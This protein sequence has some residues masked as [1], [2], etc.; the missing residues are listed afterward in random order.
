MATVLKQKIFNTPWLYP[1]FSALIA[2]LLYANTIAHGY[3]LD[4][5]AVIADNQY[6]KQGIAG[7]G[8]L[9][10]S[11]MWHFENVK[12]GYYRPLSL[13]TFAIEQQ[14]FGSS[15]TISHLVNILLYS[16]TAWVT[17]LLLF[18][19][20]NRLHPFFALLGTL[21]F[22]AHP[23]H[24]EV[25]AN[26]K[27]R[28]EILSFLNLVIASWCLLQTSES[29]RNKYIL[30]GLSALFFYLAL[31]SKESAVVGVVLIPFLLWFT[32]EVS[33]K[34]LAYVV[35]AGV[36]LVGLFQLQKYL[37]IGSLGGMVGT[38]IVNYPYTQAGTSLA[39]AL[40]VFAYSIKM[41]LVPYPQLYSYAYNQL[42]PADYS[43]PTCWVGLLLL[44]VLFYIIYKQ[45]PQRSALAF[46]LVWLIITLGPSIGFVVLRGGIFAERFLYAPT[47][48]FSMAVVYLLAKITGNTFQKSSVNATIGFKNMKVLA[49]AGAILLLYSFK[50][51]NR[52]ADWE[53]EF[54]LVSTDVLKAENN[55]QIQ[56]HYATQLVEQGYHLNDPLLK[57]NYFV[58]AIEHLNK[59]MAINPQLAEAYFQMG[60]AYRKLQYNFDSAVVYYNRS[61]MVNTQYASSYLGLATLYE[62]VGKEELASYY[63]NKTLQVNPVFAQAI[64]LRNKHFK[65]TQLNVTEFPSQATADTAALSDPDHDFTY[66]S[67]K[68]KAYGQ[69]GD[70]ANAVQFLE[71]AVSMQPDNEE[72]LVN[73]SV[74]LGMSR[75]YA[76]CI[77]VLNRVMLINPNNKTALNNLA[78]I[79]KHVGNQ[80]KAAECEQ[81]LRQLQFQNP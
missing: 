37:A 2:F 79:Y 63:Y 49:A 51:I 64:E 4:D 56:L 44:A 67:E 39:S 10:T 6:V 52:N 34:Q 27:S 40:M 70:F 75:S 74:A 24:T 41:L 81:R 80:S 35:V 29:G 42:P 68:G 57:Q 21:L 50:T 3:V 30:G 54:I 53:N 46:G 43:S 58:Q 19:V 36:A 72:A 32:Q 33:I 14:F 9:L 13:I 31:L 47:L 38:D 11:E 66:Y 73:L 78:I 61:M 1:A 59:A 22:V 15:S 26:I 45:L 16:L 65:R 18:R 25:V 28:D 5:N 60:Q 23:L 8:N 20:F 12:L 71:K 76:K 7:I 77:E 69:Q 62:S 17:C 55:C 48:G